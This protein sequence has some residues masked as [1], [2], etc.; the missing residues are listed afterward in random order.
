MRSGYLLLVLLALA[1]LCL[2]ST[3]STET[4]NLDT[5]CAVLVKLG[6]QID[7]GALELVK[8]A[9]SVAE[10]RSCILILEIDSYGGYVAAADKIVEEILRSG[11][12]CYSWI[13]PGGKA[14]SAAA[15]VALACERIYMASGSSIGAAIPI[16]RNEKTVQYVASRFKALA[17]R[18][19][20]G[21]E[22]LVRIAVSMVTNGT[23]L[24][25]EQATRIGFAK[26]ARSI[27]ELE[28][29][30]NVTVVEVLEP[31]YWEKLISL[32]SDPTIASIMLSVG[33]LLILLEVL[34][35]GFQGYAVAGA[36]LIALALYGMTMVPPDLLAL[37]LLLAGSILLAI[38]IYTPGF[39]AF[40]FTGIALTAIG[41]ALLYTSKPPETVSGLSIAITSSLLSFAGFMAFVAYKAAKTLRMKRPSYVEQLIN[42]IG[43]AKT[44]IGES[45]PGVVYVANEEWTAY[46]VRGTIEPGT[47]VKVVRVEGLKLFVEPIEDKGRDI[48][49]LTTKPS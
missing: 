40:G 36:L 4:S 38:E 3:M 20:D 48:S 18:M 24:S 31:S 16:P 1:M 5:C 2:S 47:R 23:A 19:F 25:F 22:T 46:S 44:R 32:I 29:E 49:T 17:E 30:L 43:I 15:M 21:N 39:G 7:G 11:I 9:I 45:E 12:T 13:P 37:I 28:K 34:I 41:I 8:R 10:S 33:A 27:D 6:M 26:P 42:A 35:T 14:A